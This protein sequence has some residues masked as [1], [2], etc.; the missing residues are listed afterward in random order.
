MHEHSSTV[1]KADT[2]STTR[3]LCR[4]QGPS[5]LRLSF[6][7]FTPTHKVLVLGAEMSREMS[8]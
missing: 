8:T 6:G 5:C 7:A 3:K 1:A 2:S 4:G